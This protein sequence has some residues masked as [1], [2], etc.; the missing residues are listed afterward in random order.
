[1]LAKEPVVEVQVVVK[2]KDEVE[3]RTRLEQYL[4]YVMTVQKALNCAHERTMTM[5][6]TCNYADVRKHFIVQYYLF[7]H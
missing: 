1:M 4:Q 2:E 7:D 6:L 3:W 5:Y